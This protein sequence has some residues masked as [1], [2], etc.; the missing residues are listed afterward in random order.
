[1]L[2][3]VSNVEN[4]VGPKLNSE[5]PCQLIKVMSRSQTGG[6]VSPSEFTRM[7]GDFFLIAPCGRSSLSYLCEV[8]N[9]SPHAQDDENLSRDGWPR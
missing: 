7:S 1:M 5:A 4:V 8:S 3:L 2:V 6:L 9:F